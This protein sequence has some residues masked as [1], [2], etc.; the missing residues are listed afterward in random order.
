MILNFLLI[1][2]GFA[3][4][5]F[6]ADWLVN[7]ASGLA[8]KYNVSDMV[9]GLT[10]V[11]FGTSAPELVV[12]S[13]ASFQGHPEIVF[14]NIIGS[15]I[16]NTLL[17]LGI[18]AMVY[19]IQVNKQMIKREIPFSIIIIFIVMLLSNSILWQ[20][21]NILTQWEAG[22][23]L[24]LFLGFL[25]YTFRV[26][27]SQQ[28]A[29]ESIEGLP[30]TMFKILG[31]IVLGLILL[32]LGGQLVVNNAISLAK[33]FGLSEKIIALTIVAA[34]TSLPELVTSVVAAAKKKS[35]IAIG[36]VIGSNIFNLLFI[37]SVSGIV[38]PI[39]FNP[40]FNIELILVAFGSILVL[41]FMKTGAKNQIDRWEGLILFLLMVGYTVF[42]IY[43]E[44]IGI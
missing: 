26:A 37:I 31:L 10:I 43:R 15:N 2:L 7:G 36:N 1:I 44:K 18:V 40:A 27:K 11:A 39:V 13:F 38:S 32:I 23:L 5:I 16:F 3:A 42:L 20:K 6:G 34:G 8:K 14:G 30:T 21:E 33:Q 24:L 19:P 41:L 35:D 4:L 28:V 17:I 25:T 29:E 22:L 12:N 9:I